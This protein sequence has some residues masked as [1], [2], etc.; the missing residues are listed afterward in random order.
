[1]RALPAM[2][3]AVASG[4]WRGASRWQ[5]A[6]YLAALLYVVSPVDVVP[7]LLLGP[8][9]LADDVAVAALA[10]T[11]LVRSVDAYLTDTE[12]T[13]DHELG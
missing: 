4:R 13:A 12:D 2:L 9:G 6:G 7:E 8:F 11:G 10:V 1:M 3:G 5:L